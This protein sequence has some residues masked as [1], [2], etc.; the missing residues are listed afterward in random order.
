M[1]PA[2]ETKKYSLN[3]W[4]FSL[5]VISNKT[6]TIIYFII[7]KSLSKWFPVTLE[8]LSVKMPSLSNDEL[9]TGSFLTLQI[10]HHQECPK[11]FDSKDKIILQKSKINKMIL[12]CGQNHGIN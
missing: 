12:Q 6:I 9:K 5:K 8:V 4:C 11:A 7:Y 10:V 3:E 2:L 1:Y